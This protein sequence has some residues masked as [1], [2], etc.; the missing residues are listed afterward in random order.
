MLKMIFVN[1]EELIGNFLLSRL[2]CM[3][4]KVVNFLG[5]SVEKL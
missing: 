4:R 1:E 3:R 5:E 2:S